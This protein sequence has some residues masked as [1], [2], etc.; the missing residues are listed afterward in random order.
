MAG[1]YEG[2]ITPVSEKELRNVLRT[3]FLITKQRRLGPDLFEKLTEPE[4][5]A[6]VEALLDGFRENGWDG[7][8]AYN[9]RCGDGWEANNPVATTDIAQADIDAHLD[10][11]MGRV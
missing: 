2:Q 11:L 3:R 5:E 6:G 7:T 9:A 10:A 1:R 8:T 4:I